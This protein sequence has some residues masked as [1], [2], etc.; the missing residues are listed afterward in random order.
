[1]LAAR[2]EL[3]PFPKWLNNMLI[4]IHDAERRCVFD[5]NKLFGL[6]VFCLCRKG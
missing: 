1:M 3:K 2:S 4:A 5:L 6:S